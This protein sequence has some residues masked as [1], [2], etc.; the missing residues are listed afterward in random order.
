[1][2]R[3]VAAVLVF[4]MMMPLVAFA[5]EMPQYVKVECHERVHSLAM[6]KKDGVWYVKA[7]ALIDMAGCDWTK[8]NG[9]ITIYSESNVKIYETEDYFEAYSATYVPLQEVSEKIGVRFYVGDGISADVFRTPQQL[10]GEMKR[11]YADTRFEIEQLMALPAWKALLG[12]S[13]AYNVLPLVGDSNIVDELTGTAG[14]ERYREAMMNILQYDEDIAAFISET[15]DVA[16]SVHKYAKYLETAENLLK[17]DGKIVKYLREKGVDPKVLNVLIFE[18]DPTDHLDNFFQ[19]WSEALTAINFEHF[20]DVCA[21]YAVALDAEEAMLIA[22]KRVFVDSD[23]EAAREA[24]LTLYKKR[25]GDEDVRFLADIYGGTLWDMA[26]SEL[27]DAGE[28]LLFGASGDA[29]SLIAAGIDMFTGAGDKTNAVLMG[30]TYGMLQKDLREYYLAHIDD[31][32]PYSTYDL[33]AV[34]IMYL[35]AVYE[36]YKLLEFDRDLEKSVDN[37]QKIIG[38]KLESILSYSEEEYMP[39]FSN[40]ALINWLDG[41]DP[42]EGLSIVESVYGRYEIIDKSMTWQEASEYC[43]ARGGRLLTIESQEE[44]DFIVSKLVNAKSNCYWIGLYYDGETGV[45]RC[46]DGTEAQYFNWASNEPNNDSNGSGEG[47]VHLFGK[48]YTGGKGI[49]E[50]GQWNDVGNEGAGYANRFYELENFGLVCEWD[51]KPAVPAS[52]IPEGAAAFNGHY[53]KIYQQN[54]NWEDARA[55]CESLGGHLAT[56]T[57]AEED[58]FLYGLKQE[59]GYGNVYFGLFRSDEDQ[60]WYWVNGEGISYTNWHK[61]EPNKEGG[62]EKYG[63]YYSG[64]A[65]NTWNDGNFGRGTAR[66]PR[67]VPFICEWDGTVATSGAAAEEDMV[68]A[69]ALLLGEEHWM[70][71]GGEDVLATHYYVMDMNG[72]GAWEIIIYGVGRMYVPAFEIYTYDHG[73]MRLIGDSVNTCDLS[74]W[75]NASHDVSICDGR[76]VLAEVGKATVGIQANVCNLLIFD[77]EAMRMVQTSY[78]EEYRLIGNSTIL[79]GIEIGSYDDWI[80]QKYGN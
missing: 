9:T 2:K 27:E 34:T 51:P 55:Y 79:N 78:S 64:F 77:G 45:W 57:S 42:E 54:G 38:A 26:V 13:H 20:L 56:I 62:T 6:L 68:R 24:A 36:F 49:K 70:K 15:A 59:L 53:Y 5:G 47:Y 41:C 1:M 35:K 10:R 28:K 33:R 46:E 69:A 37:A 4:L 50:I 63:M 52:L 16:D 25:F 44:M 67:N 8:K 65:D 40:K 12:L 22:M 75:F 14:K 23:N 61:G 30:T 18:D 71:T 19:D 73:T 74:Y 7:S 76:Y 72:D 32:Q 58:A 39:S 11:I 60:A 66:D 31:A 80:T 43:A 3:F 17:E 29:G 48:R 21:Y